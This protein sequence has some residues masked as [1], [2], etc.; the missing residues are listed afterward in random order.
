M[1]YEYIYVIFLNELID[2]QIQYIMGYRNKQK[3]AKMIFNNMKNPT[4]EK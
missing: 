3:T 1:S 4:S 2:F